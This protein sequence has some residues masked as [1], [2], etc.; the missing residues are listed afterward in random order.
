MEALIGDYHA[1]ISLTLSL[2][3]DAGFDA[4]THEIDH[5]CYRCATLAEYKAKCLAL[6]PAWGK[7]LTESVINGR[8]IATVLLHRPLEAEGITVR[9]LEIPAPKVGRG[10]ASGL[11]HAE[12]VVGEPADGPTGNAPLLALMADCAGDPS[13]ELGK[14]PLSWNTSSLAL[15]RNAEISCTWPAHGL[16]VKFHARPLDEVIEWEL[17]NG[18]V[19]AVAP[20]TGAFT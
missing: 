18:G 20:G 6:V 2:L 17:A 7:L 8:P 11:E 16:T 4:R 9:L 19:E 12:V 13:I 15:A 5:L 14:G 1:F 3:D 10:Y